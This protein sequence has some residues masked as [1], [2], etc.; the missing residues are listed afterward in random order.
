MNKTTIGKFHGSIYL[1][2]V[3]RFAER[4]ESAT[5]G[6]GYKMA[7]FEKNNVLRHEGGAKGKVDKR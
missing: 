4:R 3:F 2:D 6:L 5:N 1:K 7:Y